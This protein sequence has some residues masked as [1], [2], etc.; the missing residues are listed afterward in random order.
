M[1]A[2]QLITMEMNAC[3]DMASGVIELD[4]N[5]WNED[6][7]INISCRKNIF[8]IADALERNTDSPVKTGE[9]IHFVISER[10]RLVVAITSVAGTHAHGDAFFIMSVPTKEKD[11]LFCPLC[12]STGPFPAIACVSVLLDQSRE[13]TLPLEQLALD[14]NDETDMECPA[15]AFMG[16]RYH[17]DPSYWT[18]HEKQQ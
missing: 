10:L 1:S 9:S 2:E 6:N 5:G 11:L 16:R 13:V 3:I 14:T 17:F 7:V 18:R 15:C 4:L 12:G 8:H